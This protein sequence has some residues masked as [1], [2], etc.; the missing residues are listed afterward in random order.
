VPLRFLRPVTALV[1]AGT[2]A[3][4]IGLS[5]VPASADQVQSGEWWLGS[6]SVTEA[7]AA[8]QGAGVTVAVLSDGVNG[9]Q[10]DLTGAVTTAPAIPGAPVASGQ[11]FG[12]QGTAIASLIAGR[13][14]GQG[15][16]SGIIGVA[17]EASILSVPVTLP[18]DDAQL[19]LP[20]VAGA[21][22]AAIAA[23]IKYAVDH[24]ASVI[25]LPVDPGQPGS[26][27]VGWETA[28]AA[29]GSAAELSAVSYALAHNVVLVAPAGDDAV[30]GDAP[31]YP[32]AYPGVIAVGAFDS[33]FDKAAWSS[34][35]SY[36]T[37]T[38]AG[39]GVV[40][41]ANN[42]SY[43]TMNSTS[44]ASAVVAGVVALIKARYPGLSVANVRKALISTTMYARPGNQAGGSGYGAVDAV[45]ALAAAGLLATSAVARA[46]ASAQPPIVP[47][48]AAAG[49]GR[50][51]MGA[52]LLRAGEIS[53][54]LLALLLLATIGYALT[55]RRRRRGGLQAV[56]AQWVTGQ[57]QSRYPHQGHT[58]ADR[59]LEF[60]AAPLPAPGQAAGQLSG[61]RPAIAAVPGTPESGDG[62]F[63]GSEPAGDTGRWIPYGPASRA[64]SRR[65]AVAGTPPWE[66][67]APPDSDLP[68]TAGPGRLT[69]AGQVVAS[70]YP[71][72]EAATPDTE[73]TEAVPAATSWQSDWPSAPRL[74]GAARPGLD[75]RTDWTSQPVRHDEAGQ[76]EAQN[77]LSRPDWSRPYGSRPDW[78]QPDWSEPDWSKPDRAQSGLGIGAAG[79]ESSVAAASPAAQHDRLDSAGW[80]RTDADAASSGQHRS[81]LPIR[82]PR[83]VT[84]GLSPSGSLWESAAGGGSLWE[85]ADR[86]PT[87]DQAPASETSERPIFVW[88]PGQAVADGTA[89]QPGD[90]ANPQDERVLPRRPE[91]PEY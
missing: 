77:H 24:G 22:P 38:A 71:P 5:A 33:A 15:G 83:L 4:A 18:A 48:P 44:A 28:A 8:S 68:W 60:F 12:Q 51:S 81:G 79:G 36:V 31:N 75:D 40:A 70:G 52:Q 59:V 84:P 58:E 88:D 55:G 56:T 32:A 90:L 62:V 9:S 85:R 46:G 41:A 16:G 57:A 3:V 35:Q 73:H 1:T 23:G 53:A 20:A 26:A 74:T 63:P 43:Q 66:P 17:P 64:I 67:A 2:A 25:D 86:S 13:G 78:A 34:R 49:I 10:A 54:A 21:I 72:A 87:G 14:H 19:G 30:A 6:L 69:V 42:G 11:F 29:G 47:S 50:Q 27:G 76:A 39:A 89:G 7:W 61:P 91:H 65:P 80:S 37:L 45:K 82:Q